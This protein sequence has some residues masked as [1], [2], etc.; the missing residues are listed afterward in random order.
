[1]LPPYCAKKT[2]KANIGRAE[3]DSKINQKATTSYGVGENRPMNRYN[4]NS[5]NDDKKVSMYVIRYVIFIV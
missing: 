5:A 1:M 4:N 3:N 2:H